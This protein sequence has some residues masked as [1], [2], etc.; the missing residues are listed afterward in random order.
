MGRDI[1]VAFVGEQTRKQTSASGGSSPKEAERAE[2]VKKPP[3]DRA[4]KEGNVRLVCV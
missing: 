4:H 1:K 3:G 2:L